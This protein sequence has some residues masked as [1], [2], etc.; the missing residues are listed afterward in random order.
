MEFSDQ[1]RL[2]LATPCAYFHEKAEWPKY[3]LLDRKLKENMDVLQIGRELRVFMFDYSGI[4]DSGW[5]PNQVQPLSVGARHTCQTEG[6]YPELKADLDA[7]M[8]IVGLGIEQSDAAED[9]ERPRGN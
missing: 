6:I 4:I 7:C 5:D 3:G 2:C 9:D 8:Q 1:Q